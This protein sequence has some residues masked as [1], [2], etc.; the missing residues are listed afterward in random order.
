[1]ARLG[2][3]LLFVGAVSLVLARGPAPVAGGRLMW[4]FPGFL[5]MVLV[6]F[7][8]ELLSL[9][10]GAGER[11]GRRLTLAGGASFLLFLGVSF[12]RTALV[13][14]GSAWLA[15]AA[16]GAWPAFEAVREG[17][18]LSVADAGRGRA[19]SA[20]RRLAA[21][22]LPAVRFDLP[23][24]GLVAPPRG[25]WAVWRDRVEVIGLDSLGWAG[26]GALLGLGGLGLAALGPS[27]ALALGV[28]SALMFGGTLPLVALQA[29]LRWRALVRRE[30]GVPQR[31][32]IAL[33]A[34][35]LGAGCLT[36][37]LG[38]TDAGI[39]L[40]AAMAAV[41]GLAWAAG[42]LVVWRARPRRAEARVWL[43][44][45]GLVEENAQGTLLFPW[46]AVRGFDVVE[47][48][49][50]ARLRVWFLNQGLS[51][52]FEL[53]GSSLEPREQEA[54]LARRLAR[55]ER[56][57]RRGDSPLVLE[58]E[59]FEGRMQAVIRQLERIAR[60][61]DATLALPS[62]HADAPPVPLAPP[63]QAGER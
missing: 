34:A 23:G 15:L 27:E 10:D 3:L 35:G 44:R 52:P 62:V 45:E 6:V 48:G 46:T 33:G 41:A 24:E 4:M 58:P 8:G 55:L 42:A 59:A 54:W 20:G 47:A 9:R 5:P 22:A 31:T 61:P 39:A 28:A 18:G 38:V 13:G 36:F 60:A 25:R 2:R 29:M 53:L 56:A 16:L 43:A 57:Q 11:W 51:A 17:L 37:A 63:S 49:G 50:R 32:L 26:L 1:M 40:R 30:L 21:D 12:A 7:G 14:E 19:R